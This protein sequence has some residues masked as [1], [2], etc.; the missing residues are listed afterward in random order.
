M[1]ASNVPVISQAATEVLSQTISPS[2]INSIY[3]TGT[4]TPAKA[5]SLIGMRTTLATCSSGPGAMATSLNPPVLRRTSD[6][7]GRGNSAPGS[8]KAECLNC[9]ATHTPLW[10]RGLNDELNCN[11]C[12]LYCK[13]VSCLFST[14]LMVAYSTEQHKRPRPK[15][16]R[17]THGEGRA[18]AAPPQEAV[19]MM[20]KTALGH[21]FFI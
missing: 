19:N 11:A 8:V 4:Q 7:S 21:F 16:M 1:S 2:N 5:P 6:T 15:G 12:G 3:S 20:G 14:M 18:Q 10:R 17:N 13:L 9:G